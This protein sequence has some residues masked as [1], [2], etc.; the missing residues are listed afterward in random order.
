MM[1]FP[2]PKKVFISLVLV[3]V[4]VLNTSTFHMYWVYDM[5][6]IVDSLEMYLGTYILYKRL[7]KIMSNA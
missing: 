2:L 7:Q 5:I 6:H 1:S 4:L 3:T